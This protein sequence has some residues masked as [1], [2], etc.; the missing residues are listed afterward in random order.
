M[1]AKP[2]FGG[3]IA[4]GSGGVLLRD[5]AAALV[6]GWRATLTRALRPL[7]DGIVDPPEFL[8]P[9]V[10]RR[11]GYPRAFPQHVV[12]A[13]GRSGRSIPLSPAACLHVYPLF[14]RARVPG[15]GSGIL[16]EA[17][18]ARFEG[19]RWRPPYRLLGFRMLEL[20]LV[21]DAPWVD[22][23]SARAV[24]V[25][26]DVLADLGVRAAWRPAADPFFRK[27][28]QVMQRLT[29]AKRELS[30]DVARG[31]AVASVNRHGDHFARAFRIT[32][33]TT[34]ATSAC[35]AFGLERL[36]AASLQAWGPR[37]RAWPAELR[38]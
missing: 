9:R 2:T 18:C 25:V 15:Y 3:I 20:V 36:A 14:E 28:P 32:A 22:R 33:G 13:R 23:R 27:G 37:R 12:H 24:T 7:A 6:A 1:S 4:V 29:D 31:V 30:F 8:D 19:G 21:G 11:S 17:R 34:T 16:V 35:V 10:L 5:D 26:D 38:G